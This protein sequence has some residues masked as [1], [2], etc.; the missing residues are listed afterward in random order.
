MAADFFPFGVSQLTGRLHRSYQV[1]SAQLNYFLDK[2]DLIVFSKINF[3]VRSIDREMTGAV[4]IDQVWGG[5]CGRTYVYF[6]FYYFAD[7]GPSPWRMLS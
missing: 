6:Y 7:V 5:G 1:L 2:P 4:K 3:A